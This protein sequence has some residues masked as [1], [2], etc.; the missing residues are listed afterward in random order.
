MGRDRRIEGEGLR[1][2]GRG[3]EEREGDVQGG[4]GK[5]KEEAGEER[6]SDVLQFLIFLGKSLCFQIP[7]LLREGTAIIVSP[8]ISLMIDQAR[9]NFVGKKL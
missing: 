8:L 2:E 1:M 6:A 7:A 4:Y 3:G 9:V 5:G